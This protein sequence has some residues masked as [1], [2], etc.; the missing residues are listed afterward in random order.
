M[1]TRTTSLIASSALAA[2]ALAA[3]ALVGTSAAAAPP[4]GRPFELT[5]TG[6]EEVPGPGDPDAT[7]TATFRV[8]PGLEQICYTLEVSDVDGTVVAAHIHVA[9]AGVAGP[10]V[11]PLVPP[12]DGTSSDCADVDRELALAIIKDPEQYYVNVHSTVF[13]AGAVRAQLG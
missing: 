8:N 12:T 2:A 6:A 13:P 7:G 5:M 11:V 10:V 4:S 3:T 9:P 1:R